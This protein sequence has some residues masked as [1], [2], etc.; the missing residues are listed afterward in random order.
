MERKLLVQ[1]LALFVAAQVIGLSVGYALVQEEVKASIITENPDDVVN[2]LGLFVYIIVFTGILLL[3]IKFY[4]GWLLFKL[5]DTIVVFLTSIIVFSVF[6]APFDAILV[7]AVALAVVLLR[8]VFRENIFLRNFTSLVATAGAGSII[9]VSLGV[10]PI[11]VFIV[12]LSVYDFIAV[13]KTKHMVTLAK[14][15]TKKN[16]SFTFAMPTKKHTFEL[17]TGD[18]VIPLAFAV[19]VLGVTSKQFPENLPL[20]FAAPAMV[21]LGSII[22]LL[23]TLNYSSAH[24]GKALP[25]LPPQ[26]ILMLAMLG[27][28]FA[29]GWI[30]F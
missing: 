4:R 29:M 27:I 20:I 18:M 14:S 10:V 11:L 7:L 2:S 30:K 6:L 13:F 5:L 15:I 9:G 19:S 1:L 12:L 22:G 24:V 16:L 3:I 28:S 26:T 8:W 23:F 17:G 21:L 25:A